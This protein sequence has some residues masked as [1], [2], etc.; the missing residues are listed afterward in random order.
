MRD[1]VSCF[2][3][4]AINVATQQP[5]HQYSFSCSSSAA[6]AV[7]SSPVTAAASSSS[8]SASPSAAATPSVQNAVS[9]LYRISLSSHKKPLL[10]SVTWARFQSAAQQGLTISNGPSTFKLNT[11]SGLFRKKKG[12]RSIDAGGPDSKFDV[13]WDLSS[14]RYD[15][16]P[17]PLDGFYVI[18][19]IDSEIALVLGDL[20]DE[21]AVLSKKLLRAAP[22]AAK[23]SLI[24]RQEH[25]S[26]STLYSTKAR[27]SETGGQHDILIKCSGGGGAGEKEGLKQRHHHPVL[28]VC[29]DKKVVIRVKRLQWNFRGNQTIFVDGLLVDLMWDVH[30]WFFH[31]AAAT[32]TAAAAAVF[33]FRTRSGLDSRLWL[34]EKLAQ[35][36]EQLQQQQQQRLEF[37]LLIYACKSP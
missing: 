2:S 35:K 1:F 22:A 11:S 17:E 31:P 21:S 9:S 34:E 10:L 33:M 8:S 16:G 19:L 4:N 7:V 24:S 12:S 23:V 27:F 37:S 28:S 13:Y 3:E 32:A 5:H 25:C 30:D 26:G 15:S 20:A 14:A 18:V 36:E 6:A 29:I